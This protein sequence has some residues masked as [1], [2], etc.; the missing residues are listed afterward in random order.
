MW[1]MILYYYLLDCFVFCFRNKIEYLYSIEGDLNSKCKL[2]MIY[3]YFSGVNMVD[4]Y[5]LQMLVIDYI[6]YIRLYIFLCIGFRMC[7]F[8]G[9]I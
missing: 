7:F 1:Y 6:I 9:V 8:G 2:Y 5:R 3:Q 4:K